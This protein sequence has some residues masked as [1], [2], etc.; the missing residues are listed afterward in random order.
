MAIEDAV[1]LARAVSAFPDV[2]QAFRR[3]ETLRRDRTARIQNGSRRNASIFH[4]RGV[5]AK[6]R[7][8]AAGRAGAGAMNWLYSYDPWA[9]SL[10]AG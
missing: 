6:A 10:D 9:V 3:Y 1:V 5:A 2:A 7:N 8:L 4:M